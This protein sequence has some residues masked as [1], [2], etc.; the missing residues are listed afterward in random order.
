MCQFLPHPPPC[1]PPPTTPPLSSISY[2]SD[3]SNI[4]PIA[5]TFLLYL[6]SYPTS[7]FFSSTTY[8]SSSPYIFSSRILSRILIYDVTLVLFLQNHVITFINIPLP[9]LL[10]NQLLILTFI[11]LFIHHPLLPFNRL[12]YSW[13]LR[14]SIKKSHT[15]WQMWGCLLRPWNGS[16]WWHQVCFWWKMIYTFSLYNHCIEHLPVCPLKMDFKVIPYFSSEILWLYS[17][18]FSLNTIALESRVTPFKIIIQLVMV[19]FFARAKS[20][21][22]PSW[23]ASMVMGLM[24]S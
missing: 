19:W 24:G 2:L 7:D 10:L 6:L 15:Y 13:H 1:P 4:I 23:M 8:P 11:C 5:P 3:F 12:M 22:F 17:L 20:R 21:S 14:K 16:H 9:Q 18:A